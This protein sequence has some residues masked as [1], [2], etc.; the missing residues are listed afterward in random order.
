MYR[1]PGL[2][3]VLLLDVAG[4]PYA[5]AVEVGVGETRD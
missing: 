4:N 5:D 3:P 2:E 1:Y